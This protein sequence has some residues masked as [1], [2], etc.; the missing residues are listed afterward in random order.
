MA[1]RVL[2]IECSN[3]IVAIMQVARDAAVVACH[4]R[5]LDERL[6]DRVQPDLVLAPLMS[7]TF[8]A[9]DLARRL[10]QLRFRGALVIAAPHL[11]RPELVE[12]ELRRLCRGF[13]MTL[14]SPARI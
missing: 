14:M 1:G 8:D 10:A 13:T 4:F 5:M 12:A 11:P 7:C 6:L 3:A 9:S 2:A